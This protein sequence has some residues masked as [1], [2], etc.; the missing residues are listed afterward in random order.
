VAKPPARS[1]PDE[2]HST[3]GSAAFDAALLVV[4]RVA[5]LAHRGDE[6][7][8]GAEVGDQVAGMQS[9]GQLAPVGQLG[10]GDLFAPQHVHVQGIYP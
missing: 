9:L 4:E 7:C 3:H 8:A 2:S 1:T 10:L 5:R 6:S